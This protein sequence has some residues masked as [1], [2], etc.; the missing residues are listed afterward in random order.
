MIVKYRV[1]LHLLKWETHT[2]T[3]RQNG[4]GWCKMKIISFINI[5]MYISYNP[6]FYM[7]YYL[8]WK[9]SE[10][11]NESK[12]VKQIRAQLFHGSSKNHKSSTQMTEV[13]KQCKLYSF[14]HSFVQQI[15][16]NYYVLP[17]TQ[18]RNISKHKID[19][20]FAL[21]DPTSWPTFIMIPQ[22]T[23]II[24]GCI[25]WVVLSTFVGPKSKFPLKFCW[26]TME[27]PGWPWSNQGS[28]SIPEKYSHRGCLIKKHA[29]QILELYGD[30]G[31]TIINR[32]IKA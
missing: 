16:M 4:L 8:T 23:R 21:V 25:H 6:E 7:Y 15:F 17:H 5:L 30:D 14:I 28:D 3:D 19:K 11:I 20:I 24:W 12:T 18:S 2:T 22:R 1:W 31:Y 26:F 13:G 9:L 10:K 32:K 27:Q 29:L